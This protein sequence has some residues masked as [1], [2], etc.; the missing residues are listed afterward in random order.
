MLVRVMRSRKTARAAIAGLSVGLLSLA[1]LALWSYSRTAEATAAVR[2]NT[3]ISS[4]WT[5]VFVNVSTESEALTDYL[6]ASSEVGRQPLSD[7]VDG[8]NPALTWLKTHGDPVER[9]EATSVQHSYDAYSFTLRQLVVAGRTGDPEQVVLYARAASLAASTLDKQTVTN[10]SRKGLEMSQYLAMVDRRNG[11]MRVA[12]T[13]VGLIDCLLLALCAGVLLSH[14]R[15]LEGQAVESAHRSLHDG[16]TGVANRYLLG[17]RT[18]QALRMA[19]RR[20][21]QVGLLMLDLNRFK[22]VNDTL[23]HHYGDL[24]LCRVAERLDAAMRE[25]DTVARIG[26]DEFAVLLPG[27][28]SLDAAVLAGRRLLEVLNHPA[29]LEGLVVEVDASVGA[30]VYPFHG[31]TFTE[32]LKHADSAMYKAKRGHLGVAL[33]GPPDPP[34]PGERIDASAR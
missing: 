1:A 23:G 14:Q 10:I 31:G 22:E 18:D 19:A 13:V 25:G 20:G 12:A 27:I 8:A 5:A 15:R 9:G 3:A 33:Y 17:E 26:G 4:H 2:T 11:T 34:R 6:S 28:E 16:L 29:D 32:M 21:E 7:A 30:A 24:L